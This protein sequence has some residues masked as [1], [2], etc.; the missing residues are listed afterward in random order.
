MSSYGLSQILIGRDPVPLTQRVGLPEL[1]L[2]PE[3]LRMEGTVYQEMLSTLG[4]LDPFTIP[5]SEFM[6][7]DYRRVADLLKE[8]GMSCSELIQDAWRRGMRQVVI[9]DGR[10]VYETRNLEDIPNET[11]EMLQREHDKPCYTFS[12][13][14]IVE[15]ST[16]STDT[17]YGEDY[18]TISLFLG[19]EE[20][21]ESEID[22]PKKFAR[23]NAD[24]DTGTVHLRAFPSHK[25]LSPLKDF[26]LPLREYEHLGKKYNAFNKMARM[27]VRSVEGK[28][29]STVCG[30]RVVEEWEACALLQVSPK[31]VG[32]VGRSTLREFGVVLE[33]DPLRKVSRVHESS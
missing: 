24:F 25:L 4:P 15:E 33:L 19:H 9:C 11:I 1:R 10:I 7:L 13:P 14:D 16:W 31:R 28:V 32:F 17:L 18:P 27:C 3:M 5:L 26:M 21:N 23:I 29:H 30:I 8:V 20:A 22:D 12:A 6:R 2:I